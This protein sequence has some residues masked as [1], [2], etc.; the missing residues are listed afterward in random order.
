MST[1][2]RVT[3]SISHSAP[4]TAIATARPLRVRSLRQGR[5]LLK[6]GSRSG[7]R[8]ESAA[9]AGSRVADLITRDSPGGI[10]RGFAAA[11]IVNR[12]EW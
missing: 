1:A 6:S 3:G 9:L 12:A 8:H 4:S 2:E 10:A 7:R 5:R 11:G